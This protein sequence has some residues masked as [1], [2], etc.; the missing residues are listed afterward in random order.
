MLYTLIIFFLIFHILI[1]SF[2]EI[3]KPIEPQT[4]SGNLKWPPQV[5]DRRIEDDKTTENYKPRFPVG[6]TQCKLN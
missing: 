1:L 2:R 6:G 4:G 5:V 3:Q